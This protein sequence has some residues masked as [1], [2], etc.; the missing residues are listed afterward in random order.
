MR[1][2]ITR[3]QLEAQ[4]F[5][6]ELA[7]AGHEPVIAPLFGI[8]PLPVP[9]DLDARLRGSQAIL[10]TS[11]NGASALAAASSLRTRPI[12]A[13]GQATAAAAEGLGFATVFSA[14]RD[15]EALAALVRRMLKPADGPLLHVSGEDVAVDL[16]TLLSA[17]GFT[18]DRA[19]LYAARAIERLPD[20]ARIALG[21]DTVD[22]ASFFS[23]RAATTF[24]ELVA[25][26]GLADRL[27][28]VVAVAIS[29]AA[30]NPVAS[31]GW[32]KTIVAGTPTQAGVIEA[33]AEAL[34][35]A[36]T[37]GKEAGMSDVARA[38]GGS[39]GAS[40]PVTTP[41]VEPSIPPPAPVPAPTP[42]PL[43]PTVI[44]RGPGV[45][46]SFVIGLVA[47]AVLLGIAVGVARVRPDLLQLALGTGAPTVPTAP[48]TPT[49]PATDVAGAVKAEVD[50]RVGPLAARLDAAER[51]NAALLS[52]L[53]AADRQIGAAQ[54]LAQE[55]VETRVAALRQQLEQVQRTAA[56]LQSR[57][58]TLPPPTPVQSDADLAKL[59]E[60][61]A[62]AARA[63][64]GL[65]AMMAQLQTQAAALDNRLRQAGTQGAQTVVAEEL[66]PLRA[67]LDK[68]EAEAQ[69]LA[70][71]VGA[72]TDSAGHAADKD[73]VDREIARVRTEIDTQLAAL[74]AAA[75][76]AQGRTQGVETEFR[77]RLQ[78]LAAAR[79]D[80]EK[81]AAESVRAA[82]AI[83]LSTRLRQQVDTGTPFARE[84]EL[85]KP[86][87]TQDQR[88]TEIV[89]ALQP[90]AG[91]GVASRAVL[92][93]S[94]AP[95]AKAVLAADLAD[96][97]LGERALGALKSLVSVRRVGSDVPGDTVEARLARAE[98]ALES[99]D[100]AGAVA[101]VKQ[102]QGKPAE[103]A[104]AWLA[105][106]E[107][108]VAAQAALDRLAL[109]GVTLFDTA[110]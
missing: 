55:A 9:A 41:P 63:L 96:D 1:V 82:A 19:E 109:L 107:A 97:S 5:A 30:L 46:G 21:T 98:A 84:L 16:A 105:R 36:R 89:S 12:Y 66:T 86:L 103:A 3:P 87:V 54:R 37:D 71:L 28:N 67:R 23:P 40:T 42:A 94:F 50:A 83:A 8:A 85:M 33:L 53:D 43:P 59:R 56:D 27:G 24:A 99:G 101:L 75:Q 90:L 6:R 91:S 39:A 102:F 68:L 18:V 48:T 95:M 4:R 32:R 22:A 60:E 26:A 62:Q 51:Q 78:Q 34:P 11:A 38:A 31:L 106:A 93:E 69:R 81:R 57:I 64:Q 108:H 80:G 2:L 25:K 76:Q 61:Q 44:R 74:R 47:A 72:A 10:L 88:F 73:A 92:R 14:D 29:E 70:K 58:A 65:Q 45:V 77:Q 49:M 35:A 52:R 20:A 79:G 15:A 100:V 13:V 110:Q 104:A 7:V 17:D